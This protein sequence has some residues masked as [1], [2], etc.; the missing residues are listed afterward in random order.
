MNRHTGFHRDIKSTDFT[1]RYNQ[2]RPHPQP[3]SEWRR[4][5]LPRLPLP[6]GLHRDGIVG[7]S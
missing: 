6:R 1:E 7:L 2:Q 3:L 4:E 5:W